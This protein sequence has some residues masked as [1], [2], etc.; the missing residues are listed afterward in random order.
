MLLGKNKNQRN[1]VDYFLTWASKGEGE[2]IANH[3]RKAYSS[4]ILICK[5]LLQYCIKKLMHNL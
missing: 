4:S 3:T 2:D 5:E 1:R